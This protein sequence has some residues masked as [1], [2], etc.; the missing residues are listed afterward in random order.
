MNKKSLK[1]S[2]KI[3]VEQTA[4]LQDLFSTEKPKLR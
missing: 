3:Q 4:D 1:F 2:M